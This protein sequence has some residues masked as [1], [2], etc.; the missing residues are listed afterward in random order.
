MRPFAG[1]ETARGAQAT[2]ALQ[3]REPGGQ[4]RALTHGLMGAI[5]SH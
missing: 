1:S 2:K 3:V 5:I 4:E